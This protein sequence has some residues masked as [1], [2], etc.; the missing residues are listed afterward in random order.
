MEE[1]PGEGRDPML[2]CAHHPEALQT[3][4]LWVFMEAASL[5]MT[6]EIIGHW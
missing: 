2:L 1:T 6:D 3:P 5:G 4:S